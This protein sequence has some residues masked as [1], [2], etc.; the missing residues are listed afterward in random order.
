WA[1]VAGVLAAS[2]LAGS[3]RATEARPQYDPKQRNRYGRTIEKAL[4]GENVK[5]RL[6]IKEALEE[7]GP[8]PGK[9]DDED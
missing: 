5:D 8:Y 1:G 7:V 3:Q 2:V 6:K 9:D 4:G